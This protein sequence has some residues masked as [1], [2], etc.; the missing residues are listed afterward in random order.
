VSATPV[1]EPVAVLETTDEAKRR[2]GRKQVLA[3]WG[4]AIPFAS[5][6]LPTWSAIGKALWQGDHASVATYIEKLIGFAEVYGL[7]AVASML[8]A[9][10]VVTSIGAVAGAISSR[11]AEPQA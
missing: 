1:N 3:A 7:V 8:V 10:G 9:A 6:M 2:L 11:R 4:Y 5:V